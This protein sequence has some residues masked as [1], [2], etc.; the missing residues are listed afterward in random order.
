MLKSIPFYSSLLGKKINEK[1]NATHSHVL[2]YG[3][4]E[5][6]NF[7]KKGCIASNQTIADETGLTVNTVSKTISHL[8]EVGWI[9]VTWKGA[10]HSSR[11]QIIPLLELAVLPHSKTSLTPE[12]NQSYPPV[13]IDNSRGNSIDI[14]VSNVGV[15]EPIAQGKQEQLLKVKA[16][17]FEFDRRGMLMDMLWKT[18]SQREAAV[19]LYDNKG[20]EKI[21]K[22]L[23]FYLENKKVEFCPYVAS[24]YELA[25]KWDKLITFKNK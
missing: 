19:L 4:I 23:D 8:V 18:K 9:E 15:N 24:P 22:A 13:K 3:A 25:N 11:D 7:G 1:V 20:L 12:Y 17:Y 6:H 14:N 16:V 2:V 21:G 5:I 10:K